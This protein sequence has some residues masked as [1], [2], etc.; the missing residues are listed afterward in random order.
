MSCTDY[1]VLED[2]SATKYELQNFG[3]NRGLFT[4]SEK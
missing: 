3:L 2:S 1:F 4:E